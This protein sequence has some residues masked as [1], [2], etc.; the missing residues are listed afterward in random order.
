MTLKDYALSV[1][2]HYIT[3]F[4]FVGITN[5]CLLLKTKENTATCKVDNI[6]NPQSHH[7]G[8]S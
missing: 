5:A 4:I 6:S 8:K 1:A 2:T 3:I 7:L